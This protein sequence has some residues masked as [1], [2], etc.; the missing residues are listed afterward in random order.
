MKLSLLLFSLLYQ[1]GCQIKNCLYSLRIFKPKKAPLP[2]ISVGNISFGGTE[3][4]PLVIHLIEF[5]AEHGLNPALVTRGYKGNWEK[6]GGVL[7]YGKGILGG[8]RD[9]G[10]EPFMVAR[11]SPEAGIFIGKNRLLSCQ[12]AK[13]SGFEVAV[14]DDGFQHRRLQRDIDIVLFDPAQK[15]ALREPFS[16]LR[17]ADILFIKKHAHP[18]KK[19]IERRFP[20]PSIFEY[21]VQSQGLFRIGKKEAAKIE[22]FKEKVIAF[23]GIARPERFVSSLKEEGIEPLYIFKF[24]DHHTYPPS[25]VK[26]IKEKYQKLGAEALLTTEKD[27]VKLEANEDINILPVYY[28]K[29]ELRIEKGFD[30]SLAHLVQNKGIIV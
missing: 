27:A 11:N 7:S 29:I 10:D 2:V 26:K 17:R 30:S 8:W 16:A 20:E 21:F 3:K 6:K 12:K 25:S 13:Q 22:D 4:T 23:C 14:L 19:E 9:S 24:P 5:L 1:S 15:V 28:L 18:Q